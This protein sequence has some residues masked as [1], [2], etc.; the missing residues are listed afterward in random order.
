MVRLLLRHCYVFMFALTLGALRHTK[1]YLLLG[2]R[3]V[4]SVYQ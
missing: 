4:T 3:D 2:A 1:T